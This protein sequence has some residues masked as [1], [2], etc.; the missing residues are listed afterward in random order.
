M[1][2]TRKHFQA[3]DCFILLTKFPHEF[4]QQTKEKK[5]KKEQ[6]S[7]VILPE[8]LNKKKT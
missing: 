1:T 5:R 2:V 8:F 6:M 7:K 4:P 3:I